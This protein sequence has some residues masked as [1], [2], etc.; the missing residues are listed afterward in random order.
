MA[1]SAA[2]EIKVVSMDI[3]SGKDSKELDSNEFMPDTVLTEDNFE[4][5]YVMAGIRA[6]VAAFSMT[7]VACHILKI[8]PLR[9][10]CCKFTICKDCAG[11]CGYT[12]DR[13][14]IKECFM[15]HKAN[16]GV[17]DIPFFHDQVGSIKVI[18]ARAP[19]CNWINTRADW[20]AHVNGTCTERIVKCPNNGCMRIFRNHDIQEH[21]QKCIFEELVCEQC[22]ITRTRIFYENHKLECPK[23]LI[24]CPDCSAAPFPLDKE[25]DHKQVCAGVH[26]V[27]PFSCGVNIKRGDLDKHLVAT[28]CIKT[29]ILAMRKQLDES[30]NE[31][32]ALRLKYEGSE[33]KLNKLNTK[34]RARVEVVNISDE[35][36]EEEEEKEEEDNDDDEGTDDDD[37]EETKKRIQRA[38]RRA[39]QGLSKPKQSNKE[40]KSTSE[41]GLGSVEASPGCKCAPM[42]S[43]LLNNLVLTHCSRFTNFM[44]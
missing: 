18:C 9:S 22:G 8:S 35:E 25:T 30:R 12:A 6:S 34:K 43:P 16:I 10:K 11:K 3:D 31:V 15:C 42:A 44:C 14:K 24:T 4:D 21:R 32:A 27:C 5:E 40:M 37:E 1:G 29:H 36:E 7:C 33:E 38:I 17:E 26:I 13:P 2:V 28:L 23:R 41:S 20:L 19:A 39:D